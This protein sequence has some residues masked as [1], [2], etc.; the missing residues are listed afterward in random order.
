[1]F[2]AVNTGAIFK[3]SNSLLNKLRSDLNITCSTHEYCQD[4]LE[5][6]KCEIGFCRCPESWVLSSDRTKC[7][8]IS[9]RH[10]SPCQEN[11]QCSEILSRGGICHEYKCKCKTGY[12]YLN[13]ICWKSKGL[14]Q[15]CQSTEECFAAYDYR[16]IECINNTCS[17]KTGF[18]ERLDTACR[19]SRNSGE[20]CGLDPDCGDGTSC[21]KMKCGK[22]KNISV[23]FD[24]TGSETPLNNNTKNLNCGKGTFELNG[25]CVLELGMTCSSDDDCSHIPKAFCLDGICSCGY[26]TSISNENNTKCMQ[27]M[28]F[29]F[30]IY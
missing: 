6:S 23:V 4:Y 20:S 18:Y 29:A 16:G 10:G 22:P 25:N 8:K 24:D 17:C 27:G 15:S 9:A 14:K 11:I 2:F 12:H 21:E 13:G 3:N 5:N 30:T 1:M 26:V 28:H 19:K 7:L